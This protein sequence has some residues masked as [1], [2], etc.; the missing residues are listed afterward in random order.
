MGNSPNA[1]TIPT[2]LPVEDAAH[3]QAIFPRATVEE[4]EG[5]RLL[6]FPSAGMTL[7]LIP[8]PNPTRL[9][10]VVES[11]SWLDSVV[12]ADSSSTIEKG[13]LNGNSFLEIRLP[14]GGSLFLIPP[15]LVASSCGRQVL[16]LRLCGDTPAATS[17]GVH[18]DVPS[19]S[20]AADSTSQIASSSRLLPE[21]P[22]LQLKLLNQGGQQPSSN[23][24]LNSRI[25][26]PVETDLFKGNIICVVRPSNPEDDPYWNE[27]IFSKKKRR[28][29][30]QIQGQF[31]YEPKGVVYAGAEVSDPMKL[32]LITRGVSTILLRLV[33]SFNSN[34]HYSYGDDK[35]NAH[36]V[37]PAFTFFERIIATPPGQTPPLIGEPF[38]ETLESRD[39]RKASKASGTWNAVDTYSLE[40]YSMYIDLPTWNLV[41]LPV[42]GDIA[43]KTFWGNSLLRICMYE[44]LSSDLAREQRHLEDLKKYVFAV[45]VRYGKKCR[46]PLV[47]SVTDSPYRC[48]DQ[49]SGQGW[50][51]G[52]R[53][54]RG[55]RRYHAMEW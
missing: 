37:G 43:L 5:S 33:E 14:G 9:S 39:Y 35:E 20:V 27:R 44:N 55:T 26:I 54:R 53:R 18:V 3:L 15:E 38:E 17:G 16:A 24:P 22:S 19:D 36:I 48:V 4:A 11:A 52:E 46:A 42:S 8:A 28:L 34:I 7:I 6:V 10:W 30:I 12:S 29:V 31:K 13:Y 45:Q 49:I 32:G 2:P 51:H 41:N 1:L 50:T 25:P 21:I 47:W 40:F 23:F